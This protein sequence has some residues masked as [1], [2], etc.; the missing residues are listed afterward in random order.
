LP[1]RHRHS[2]SFASLSLLF[3]L[4]VL[5]LFACGGPE[6]LHLRVTFEELHGLE[7]GA[8]VLHRGLVVGKVTDIGL[9]DQ[10]LVLVSLTIAP[11]YR[12]AVARNSI[13]RVDAV[14][15]RRRRQLVIEEGPGARIPVHEG[16]VLTGS[17]GLMDDTVS[18]IQDAAR[19]VWESATAIAGDVAEALREWAGSDDA[20]ELMESLDG[21][22]RQTTD[23]T[24]E[25]WRRLREEDLPKLRE[26]A[27]ELRRRLAEG[28]AQEEA[29]RFWSRFEEEFDKLRAAADRAADEDLPAEKP[30]R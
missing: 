23:R 30:P 7:R 5:A 1:G 22:R 25:E 14:G 15:L 20:R 6:P 24:R 2:P 21:L 9:D 4:S 8:R 18:E 16:D 10:G 12:T 26:R 27:E 17:E 3:L 28:G 11:K 29:E 19:E 13:I